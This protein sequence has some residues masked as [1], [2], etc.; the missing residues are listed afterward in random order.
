MTFAP[1]SMFNWAMQSLWSFLQKMMNTCCTDWQNR[2]FSSGC[3]SFLAAQFSPRAI[4][5][6]VPLRRTVVFRG[7]QPSARRASFSAPVNSR[8]SRCNG[9]IANTIPGS[10]YRK[11]G[12]PKVIC[13]RT[14]V[15]RSLREWELRFLHR[16]KFLDAYR[17]VLAPLPTSPYRNSSSH[18]VEF[19]PMPVFSLRKRWWFSR[20]NAN[21]HAPH[22]ALAQVLG[23]LGLTHALASFGCSPVRN[24]SHMFRRFG[25]GRSIGRNRSTRLARLRAAHLS[26]RR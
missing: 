8:R 13:R 4:N 26:W 17:K 3:M 20:G 24:T 10:P 5:Y 9:T 23:N 21:A 7:G 2:P 16:L 12:L 6:S 11:E 1:H 22:S 18:R 19:F 14:E 15:P 25:A